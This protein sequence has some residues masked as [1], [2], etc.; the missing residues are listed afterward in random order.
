MINYIIYYS[1]RKY[2]NPSGHIFK[3]IADWKSKQKKLLNHKFPWHYR[4]CAGT[5]E[6]PGARSCQTS[7]TLIWVRT[8]LT[9]STVEK[10]PTYN[11]YQSRGTSK[12]SCVLKYAYRRSRPIRRGRRGS[13]HA[14]VRTRSM[15]GHCLPHTYSY[16]QLGT[17]TQLDNVDAMYVCVCGFFFKRLRRGNNNNNSSS[18]STLTRIGIHIGYGRHQKIP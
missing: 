16:T 3:L 2:S 7:S 5:Y 12:N 14:F 18:S 1:N 15:I 6:T 10:K 17:S 13:V 4:V 11:E 8:K 9:Q